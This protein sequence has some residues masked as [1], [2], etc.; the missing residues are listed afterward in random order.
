MKPLAAFALC[1][2]LALNVAPASAQ[3]TPGEARVSEFYAVIASNDCSMTLDEGRRLLAP[4]GFPDF[5]EV[6]RIVAV[7]VG[8]GRATI[9]GRRLSVV[10]PGCE[11]T[12]RAEAEELFLVILAA[13]GC[14]MT[15]DDAQRL[16]PEGGL[17]LQTGQS[18]AQSYF[19]QGLARQ[20]PDQLLILSGDVCTPTG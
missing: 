2:S 5:G 18:I 3:G 10:G 8:E 11:N 9:D 15:F 19:R 17:A 1:A 13:N 6:Q 4:A 7:R 12:E 16:L 14:Q 20:G